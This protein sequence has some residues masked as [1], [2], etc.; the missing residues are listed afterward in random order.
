MTEPT[1]KLE[2]DD[3]TAARHRRSRARTWLI[4]ALGILFL[5]AAT[6]L[7]MLRL[8]PSPHSQSD[9]MIAGGAATMVSL[10]VLFGALLSTALK[11]SDPF[12]KRRLR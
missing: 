2:P 11:P 6:V 3:S 8:L 1:L 10:L 7:L 4:V 5:F 9:Y 12:F